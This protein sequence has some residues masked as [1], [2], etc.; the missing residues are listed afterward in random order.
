MPTLADGALARTAWS[1]F[2]SEGYVVLR[3]V[4]SNEDP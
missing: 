1:A 3:I 2:T 4:S